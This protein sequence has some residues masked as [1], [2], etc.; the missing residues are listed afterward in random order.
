MN[1]TRKEFEEFLK[2]CF[3]AAYAVKDKHGASMW[4]DFAFSCY[5]EGIKSANVKALELIDF[6]EETTK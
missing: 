2:E 5:C 4:V 1:I 6:L 3:P